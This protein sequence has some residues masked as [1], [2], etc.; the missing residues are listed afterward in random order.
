MKTDPILDGLRRLRD[1]HA[2]Q[3]NYDIAAI[4]ADHRRFGAKLKKAGWRFVRSKAS[5][6]RAKRK[7][8]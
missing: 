1:E 4:A 3:F 7:A 6:P 2:K 5:R 8:A